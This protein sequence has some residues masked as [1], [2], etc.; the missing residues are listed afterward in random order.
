MRILLSDGSGLTS[1]QI[2]T[3]LG[4]AGHTVEVLDSA[5]FA[6]THMTRWVKAVHKVPPYGRD[7][8]AWLTEALR[9][10]AHGRFD[11]LLPSQEQVAVLSLE[12]QRIPTGMAVPD[13]AAL[14]RV[15]D[16]ISAA[17]VLTELDLPQPPSIVARTCAELLDARLP[18]FVKRPVGTAS[19]GVWRV[20]DRATLRAIADE[21]ADTDGFADGDLLVQQPVPGPL[22]MV[23]AVYDQGRLVAW[24]ASRRSREGANGGASGKTS[25]PVPVIGAHL[26]RLGG[27]LR[28]HGALSIDAILTPG[29]PRYIDLNPRIVE[30]VNALRAGVDLLTPLLELSTGRSPAPQPPGTPDIHTHQLVLALTAAAEHG[31]R[32][33]LRELTHAATRTG[34]YR[35]STE[36]LT[37]LPGDPRS[38]LP[39]GYVAASLLLDPRRASRLTSGAVS[40]YALTPTAWRTILARAETETA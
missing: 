40:N 20:T 18:A 39:L 4:R 34:P 12:H 28:W 37:P 6:L 17:A 30:P 23:Q 1:R 16:K 7:P 31:R 8:Y 33:V 25:D 21:L 29:G 11:V 32:A 15:Q 19:T 3:I 36:E 14:R 26:D 5:G 22:A 35:H 27:A 38:L 24:H 13:F 9:V 10:L 2:A